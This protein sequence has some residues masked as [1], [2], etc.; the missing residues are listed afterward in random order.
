MS[1][2]QTKSSE[3]RQAAAMGVD[4]FVRLSGICRVTV[5]EEIK[6][7]GQVAGIKVIRIGTRILLP[8]SRVHEVFGITA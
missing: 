7:S 4:E 2:T 1:L 3:P 5:Y 8:R 6:R